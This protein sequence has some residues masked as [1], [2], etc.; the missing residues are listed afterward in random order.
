M[1]DERI[2]SDS[3]TSSYLLVYQDGSHVK[4]LQSYMKSIT[5]KQTLYKQEVV[6]P[7]CTVLRA[8]TRIATT[9]LADVGVAWARL[10]TF[11]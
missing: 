8:M 3:H 11:C 1:R 7:I 4:T 9:Y 6:T 5:L 10:T 2:V